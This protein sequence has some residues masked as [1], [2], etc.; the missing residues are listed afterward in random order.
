MNQFEVGKTYESR[1]ACDWNC[2]WTFTVVKRTAQFITIEGRALEGSKR[3]KIQKSDSGEFA[4]W[5]GSYSMAPVIR[6]YCP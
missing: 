6:A 4:L 1:S 3:V 2:V 5:D